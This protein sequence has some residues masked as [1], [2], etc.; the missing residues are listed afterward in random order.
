MAKCV[1]NSQGSTFRVSFD[2]QGLLKNI[3]S[4]DDLVIVNLPW[5]E[6]NKHV[7]SPEDRHL[8]EIGN[9]QVME[10]LAESLM[11]RSLFD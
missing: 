9:E 4:S 1:S 7:V 3:M 11:E 6:G 8:N 2:Y 5:G 10:R